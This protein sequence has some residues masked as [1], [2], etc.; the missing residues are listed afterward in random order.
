[1]SNQIFFSAFCFLKIHRGIYFSKYYDGGGGVAAGGK[2]KTEGLGKKIQRKEK[3]IG[4]K[5]KN[6]FKTA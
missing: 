6:C 1:M 4:K 3:G 5:T 2:N